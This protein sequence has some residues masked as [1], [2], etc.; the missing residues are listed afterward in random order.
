MKKTTI[1]I[2][3]ETWRRLN[4]IKRLGESFDELINR[5]IESKN[6]EIEVFKK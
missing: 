2:S 6:K 1:T 5:I 3:E 4:Q